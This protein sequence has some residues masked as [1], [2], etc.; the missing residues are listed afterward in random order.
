M[1]LLYCC[2]LAAFAATGYTCQQEHKAFFDAQ[3]ALVKRQERTFPP[4]LTEQEATLVNSINNVTIDQWWVP[5]FRV[6][7]INVFTGTTTIHTVF[8]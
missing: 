7:S 2:V 8:I 1:K 5:R 3:V 4:V 6:A